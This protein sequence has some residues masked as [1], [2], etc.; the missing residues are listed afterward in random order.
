VSPGPDLEAALGVALSDPA[1]LEL[2]LT[3]RSYAYEAGGLPTNER[4]EFL[5]DAVLG[6]AVADLLYR[7]HPEEPESRL[8]K[9]R[10]AVVST[11]SLAQVG[12]RLGLG[13]HLR[14]GRGE[15]Q[16]GGRDKDSLLANAV[17]A[18]LGA[19]YLDGG[20]TAAFALVQ[21]LF[22]GPLAEIVARGE[23]RDHKTALQ[24]LAA[25]VLAIAPVYELT[26]D[27]PD[28]ARHFTA[29]AVLD[30]EPVG[31]GKGR[32]KKAAEQE[33]AAE[34]LVTLRRRFALPSGDDAS[35]AT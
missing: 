11:V 18:L 16:S 35:A 32:S 26:G 33:A 5:G 10:A 6:L 9:L 24:E 4:L 34:A 15:E 7:E 17:E 30:G 28:H 23:S 22:A 20:L 31:R 3:H 19:V 8:S 1:L 25:A 14:L 12:R 29:V 27:G 2:A 13:A 21:R